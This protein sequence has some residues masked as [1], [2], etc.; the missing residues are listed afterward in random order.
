MS[1]SWQ[2]LLPSSCDWCPL[3]CGANRLESKCGLCGANDKLYVARA[4]AHYWEEPP[5]SGTFG[6]P[7]RGTGLGSGTI[8]F[9]NC[10]MKCIY[11]QNYEISGVKRHVIGQ[12]K[13]LD[14]LVQI[15]LDM[16]NQGLMNINFVTGTHYRS[17]IITS[18]RGAKAQGLDIPII[19]NSSGYETVASIYALADTV[20]VWLPD[21]KYADNDLAKDLSNNPIENYSEVAIQAIEAMLNLKPEHKFDNFN[22]NLRMT[23]GVVVRHMLLPGHLDNSKKALA[24]L[25]ENF[26]NEIK[27]SIM[28]QYT[29]VIDAKYAEEKNHTELLHTADSSDYDQLLD[30]ADELGLKDYY[31]Q[32]GPAC[33]ESFI[34][35]WDKC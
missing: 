2:N 31:W 30:Y 18:V 26:G 11:C 24:M 28:N 12:E 4:A 27:Y 5:I 15:C 29:P 13:S 33:S 20:D 35:K 7:Q 22:E 3:M 9:S 34:P 8:F 10:N 16:Q 19:W 14:D 1:K 6:G 25:F 17:H 23:Q 21:F 32:Q